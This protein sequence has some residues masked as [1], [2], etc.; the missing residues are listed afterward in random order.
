MT[1]PLNASEPVVVSAGSGLVTLVD[2]AT[3]CLS[4]AT[5]DVIPG[6]AQG[7]YFRDARLL[8]RF[9]LR[10]DG[11]SP[12]PLSVLG[13]EAYS[14]RFL[15]RRP[16]VPGRADSTLLLV[17]ERLVADGLR[18]V[19][20][21]ENLGTEATTASLSLWVSADF[22]DLFAVK[23]GRPGPGEANVHVDADALVL[24]AADGDRGLRLIATENPTVT[25]RRLHLAGGRAAAR[26]LVHRGHRTAGARR[27]R[28]AAQGQ[29]RGKSRDQRTGPAAAPLAPGQHDDH[30]RPSGARRDT[31]AD[32][33][34]PR[35]S[36]D[37]RPAR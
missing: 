28:T 24:T 36:A 29:P 34:R 9:E 7:L 2:G 22:A 25:P 16:P 37:P 33:G 18:E 1:A 6:G 21:V 32:R 5:G 19:V 23:E 27:P 3:F 17:R 30:R 10:L 26:Q 35:R 31:A 11:A 14:A 8:S 12:S 13:Q 4:E 15:L 20:T